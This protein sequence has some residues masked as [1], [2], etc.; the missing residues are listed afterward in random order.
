MEMIRMLV[1]D[2][3]SAFRQRLERALI[4]RG[5]ETF[6][7]ANY[8]EAV[9]VARHVQPHRAVVD[10]RMPGKSGLE[11]IRELAQMDPDMQI[12]VLTGF[13]AIA[14]AV[15]AVRYGAI[16]YLNKP[17]DTEEIL[18]TFDRDH[19]KLPEVTDTVPSLA[20]VEWDYIQRI[21]TESGGNISLTARRLGI[22][23]RSLQRKLGKLPPEI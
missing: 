23:R 19:E 13:G 2:D 11:L 12:V 21:L 9:E 6:A 5:F 3:D 7:A 16:D 10:L 18:A 22:H 4:A 14:S 17:A 1:V 8:D 20:R 15:E